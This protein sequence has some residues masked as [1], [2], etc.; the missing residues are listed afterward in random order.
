MADGEEQGHK[1][2]LKSIMKWL[3]LKHNCDTNKLMQEI[4]EIVVKTMLSIQP[5]L[6]HNYRICQPND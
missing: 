5:D 4:K 1:R 2:T 3:K 6:L